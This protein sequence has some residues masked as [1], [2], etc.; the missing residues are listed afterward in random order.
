MVTDRKARIGLV[1][2]G[3]WATYAHLPALAARADVELVALANRGAEK[4]RLV[5]E[6]FHVDKI[7]TDYREMLERETFD[8]VVISTSHEVHYEIA[9]AAL[10]H[11]CHALIEKPMVLRPSEA[12]ELLEVA[13][14][15]QRVIVMSYPWGYTAHVRQA[16]ATV[17]SGE[18][19][20]VE[21][22]TSLFTSYAYPSYRGDAEAFEKIFGSGGPYAGMLVRPRLD[23]SVDPNRGGG[24]GYVQVTH[25]A[26]LAFWITGLSAQQVSAYMNNLDVAVDVVDAVSMRLSNGAIGVLSSTGNLQPGD[27]GQHT[28][29]VYGSRGY[30]ILDVIEGTLMIRKDDG[31]VESPP[32]VPPDERYPRFAP[33][34]NFVDVILYDADNL[35]PGEIGRLA[36]D[37]LD[38]AYRSAAIGGMPIS[39]EYRGH[40]SSNAEERFH[41]T[42][43]NL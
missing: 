32:P 23:G 38:A 34:N 33:A 39:V 20:E 27:P 9:K 8:G 19:G 25:S 28:L 14:R 6:A 10:E 43:R 37:F 40:S 22:I 3:W 29:W 42:E 4:L 24:Q 5:A 41:G 35:A 31:T 1:G 21:L 7:Y 13:Q 2:T 30:L 18:V 17:L 26:A 16:R 12:R 36:V 11:G 15:Q